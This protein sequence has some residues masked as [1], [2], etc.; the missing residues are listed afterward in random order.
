MLL[1]A[2]VPQ[3]LKHWCPTPTL[4]SSTTKTWLFWII[5]Y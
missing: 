3:I 5:C 1:H 2:G 4:C